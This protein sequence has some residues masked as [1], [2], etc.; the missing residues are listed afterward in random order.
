M[1]V[2]QNTHG[3]FVWFTDKDRE[4][5]CLESQWVTVDAR[6]SYGMKTR[7]YNS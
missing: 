3:F 5:G 1:F 7:S 6:V 4:S 2:Q